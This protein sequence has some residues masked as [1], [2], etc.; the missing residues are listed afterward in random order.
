MLGAHSTECIGVKQRHTERCTSPHTTQPNVDQREKAVTQ[1]GALDSS[2][3][4]QAS[5]QHPGTKA[6]DATRGASGVVAERASVVATEALTAS[7]IPKEVQPPRASQDNESENQSDSYVAPPTEQRTVVQH[8][9]VGSE[10][11]TGARPVSASHE[12]NDNKEVMHG[13]IDTTEIWD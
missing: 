8:N 12:V 10:D 3:G 11:T 9:E 4:K 13:S 7:N 2:S 5:T 1:D 6:A